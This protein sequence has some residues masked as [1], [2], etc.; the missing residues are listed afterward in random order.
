MRA[1]AATLHERFAFSLSVLALVVLAA[2]LGVQ[3]RGAHLMVARANGPVESGERGVW[4][5]VYCADVAAF[6]DEVIAA[7]VEASAISY[8]FFAPRGEFRVTDPDGHVMMVTH[9]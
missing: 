1:V 5:Y 7:G 9:T 4:F 8:P 6:R 2:A 3:M